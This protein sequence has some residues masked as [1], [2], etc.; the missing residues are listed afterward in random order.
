MLRVDDTFPLENSRQGSVIKPKRLKHQSRVGEERIS[1]H[2]TDWLLSVFEFLGKILNLKDK[3][4]VT[5]MMFLTCSHV[6]ASSSSSSTGRAPWPEDLDFSHTVFFGCSVIWTF[7][8]S[9]KVWDRYFSLLQ[10]LCFFSGFLHRYQQSVI[11]GE[12][13]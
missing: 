1:W 3:N 4:I 7:S 6:K 12:D 5:H 13:S 9:G 11:W 10:D 2:Q 8:F